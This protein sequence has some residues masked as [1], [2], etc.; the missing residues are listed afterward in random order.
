MIGAATNVT[1]STGPTGIMEDFNLIQRR[2]IHRL[3]A[4]MALVTVF[5]TAVVLGLFPWVIRSSML[6][7]IQRLIHG[8]QN[9]N[10][11][12]FSPPIEVL[13]QDE[14]GFL[15]RSF[16]EMSTS[17]RIAAAEV[18]K[19][20]D[21]LEHLVAERTVEL[22]AEIQRREQIAEELD[23]ARVAAEAADQA[24]SEFVANMS[25]EIRTPLNGIIGMS[26]LLL[27]TA[28]DEQQKDLAETAQRSAEAL[29][30]IVNDIL[31][32]SKIEAGKL[33]VE[34]VD[35]NLRECV[36]NALDLVAST[37]QG[38][39]L[40]LAC[41]IHPGVPPG[42]R[43]D[44]GRLRQ[45]LLNLLGNAI[46]F[47][48]HG[49]V[50]VEVTARGQTD[51]GTRFLFS[52]HDT[53][54]GIPASRQSKLF[55][56]FTQADSSTARRFGGT[57]L[58]L[59]I[60]RRLVELMGGV[61]G[62]ES[63]VGQGSSF[64]F[65]LVLPHA[66]AGMSFSPNEANLAQRFAGL[67]ALVVHSNPRIQGILEGYLTGWGFSLHTGA[68]AVETAIAR[69]VTDTGPTPCDVVL[70]D[71]QIVS[72]GGA[73]G[74]KRLRESGAFPTAKFIA[75]ASISQRG[76]AD[77]VDESV[78]AWLVKPIKPL[79]LLRT[80]EQ[81]LEAVTLPTAPFHS[82]RQESASGKMVKA[83]EPMSTAVSDSAE[84]NVLVAEDNPVNWKLAK[85][86]LSK[87]GYSVDHA[88][89]GLEA[90]KAHQNK[91][92]DLILMDCQMPNMDGYEASQRIRATE[93]PGKH[94]WIIAM[95]ANAM[96][97]DREKCIAAGMDDYLPKPI[98]F[99]DLRECLAR[100]LARSAANV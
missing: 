37:A 6:K 67:S 15:T 78:D 58:G 44:P 52:V 32:F 88:K 51:S 64:W 12:H 39:G 26:N 27:T 22:E 79:T 17:L 45:V 29:R 62:L 31:D 94:I 96:Q 68:A 71:A 63:E 47:T 76:S 75:L 65:V 80:I 5:A 90:L 92:Y 42:V 18:Q 40:E 2:K 30:T 43:G 99:E 61:I 70:I 69:A 21:H 77:E 38:K 81:T 33:E 48:H 74:A 91:D 72:A 50:I 84:I 83:N 23:R 41:I 9:L 36:E 93:R 25:H 35:F 49:E 10:A 59:A 89:D 46:K 13:H 87:L 55:A 97:G 28:L 1:T 20:R 14:I 34:T 3:S 73:P 95:T 16:N 98:R 54:I 60:S 56:A 100:N 85:L 57:G 24:K 82:P 86:L 19:H 11:E 8:I 7:P 4:R 66:D 53:G